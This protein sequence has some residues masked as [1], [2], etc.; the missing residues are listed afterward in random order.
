MNF[1]VKSQLI[2]ILIFYSCTIVKASWITSCK[3]C[4]D[5]LESCIECSSQSDCQACA[6]NY[7]NNEC[8]K[9]YDDIFKDEINCENSIK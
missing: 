5:V 2:L 9:C 8:F 3:P 7:K 1:A 6:N 4:V